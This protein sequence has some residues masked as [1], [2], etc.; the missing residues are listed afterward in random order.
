MRS[1]RVSAV[2]AAALTTS[3]FGERSVGAATIDV[4]GD[5]PTIAQA[6]AAAAPGD[7]VH[8][9]A[10]TY[11]EKLQVPGRLIALTL[12]GDPAGGT[13]LE[14]IPGTSSDVLRVRASGVTIKD[15]EIHGGNVAIRIDYASGATVLDVTSDGAREGIR[16]N[17]AA[18]SVVA[19][20]TITNTRDGNGIS[21]NRSNDAT[22]S[23][24]TVT[25]AKREGI[26]VQNSLTA[27]V[28]AN[29]VDASQGGD[30]IRFY[31]DP[32]G[33]VTSNTVTHS[34]V[35]G[36]RIQSSP[37]VTVTGNH[38]DDNGNYG[39]RVEHSPP[40]ASS[41]DLASAAN[42]AAGNLSGDFRVAP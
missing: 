30:G 3:L 11:Q 40:I 7:V 10:G 23:G 22:V 20:S 5:Q 19:G 25:N 4:P 2:A 18:R 35:N 27:L 13:I 34:Y 28:S 29:T 39:V 6:I 9:E 12:E 16:V 17:N 21:V 37:G 38:T 1:I 14:G 33:S 24:N 8:V 26:R 32:S 36:I 42:T 41:S 31:H 15:L